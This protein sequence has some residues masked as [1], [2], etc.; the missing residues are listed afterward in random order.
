MNKVPVIRAETDLSGGEP[1]ALVVAF[2]A[3]ALAHAVVRSGFSVI[4]LDA[5]G[6]QDLLE[7]ARQ[8]HVLREWGGSASAMSVQPDR[9]GFYS[10][11]EKTPASGV[12]V[13]VFLGGGCENWP[14]LLRQLE[15]LPGVH[16][17]GPRAEQMRSIRNLE[18]WAAPNPGLTFQ[19]Q[20]SRW[21]VEDRSP[22]PAYAS[23]ANLR[24]GG[25]AAVVAVALSRRGQPSTLPG[26]GIGKK[27][28]RGACWAS[29]A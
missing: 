22:L 4:S 11:G 27:R 26:V 3:R 25:G 9:W 23:R 2:S 21:P 24:S 28:S 1:L 12:S 13:P 7:I 29:P 19:P 8:C 16:L 20:Q 15:N 17:L 10:A 6:D 18:L 14:H 5:F